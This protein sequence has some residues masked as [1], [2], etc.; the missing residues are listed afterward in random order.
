MHGAGTLSLREPDHP[1]G[2]GSHLRDGEHHGHFPEQTESQA[3]W[4]NTEPVATALNA[5]L[6][7]L[8]QHFAGLLDDG[9]S[10]ER[11]GR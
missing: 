7:L 11:V 3:G 5:V 4:F 2:S 10:I 1:S 8:H 6:V 9:D